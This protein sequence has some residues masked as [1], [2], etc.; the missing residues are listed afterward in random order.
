MTT[1][2]A[3]LPRVGATGLVKDKESNIPP[4]ERPGIS[5]AVVRF[6]MRARGGR[7]AHSRGVSAPRDR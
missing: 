7:A 5:G 4:F 6:M 1:L 3:A 2:P